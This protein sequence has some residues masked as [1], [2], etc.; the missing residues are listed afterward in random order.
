VVTLVS[1]KTHIIKLLSSRPVL[2]LILVL[3]TTFGY[4][5]TADVLNVFML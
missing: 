1:V 2:A 3:V 5:I 4:G